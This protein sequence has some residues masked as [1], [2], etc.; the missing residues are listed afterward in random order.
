MMLFEGMVFE[1]KAK[2]GHLAKI[3]GRHRRDLETALSF[4]HDQSLG[5]HPVEQF[6]QCRDRRSV[7]LADALEPQLLAGSQHAK[8]DVGPDPPIGGLADGLGRLGFCQHLRPLVRS[9]FSTF[10]PTCM[11]QSAAIKWLS[12]VACGIH[13]RPPR[14]HHGRPDHRP[15]TR[16]MSAEDRG[17][18]G[19]DR[20]ESPDDA[21]VRRSTRPSVSTRSP[22]L[23]ARSDG[24]TATA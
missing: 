19:T 23:P 17:R 3:S 2:L 14:K 6:A 8:N 15:R 1:Q 10:G 18:V 22:A 20:V 12:R 4:G 7:A 13:R 5:A 16:I 11:A 24:Q 21:A 9:E